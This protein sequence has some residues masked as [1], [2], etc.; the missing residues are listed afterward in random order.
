MQGH[1]LC[2]SLFT[3]YMCTLIIRFIVQESLAEKE[4]ALQTSHEE[5]NKMKTHYD[6][7]LRKKDVS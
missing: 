6:N 4:A 5:M 7:F 3:T 2:A 1:S